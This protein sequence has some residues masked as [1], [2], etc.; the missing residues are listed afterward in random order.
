MIIDKKFIARH[1]LRF[2]LG[3]GVIGTFFF[4]INLLTFAKVW[5]DTFDFYQIP[6]LLVYFG[7]PLFYI[8]TCWIVGYLYDTLGF[9]KEE[10][11]HINR[12][13]NPE[14]VIIMEN[15]TDIKREL[16]DLRKKI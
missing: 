10:N 16:V 4:A 11:S 3:T 2:T 5:E 9:W 1:R 13:L 7:L 14:I 12:E 15:L 6:M 8:F